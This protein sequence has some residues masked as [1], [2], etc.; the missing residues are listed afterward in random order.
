MCGIAGIVTRNGTLPDEGALRRMSSAIAHRGPDGEGLWLVPG[1]GFAHRRLAIID[2]AQTGAQ[3]MHDVRGELT[4]TYNGEIYNYREL[5]TELERSGAHFASSSDTEVILEGYRV[6]GDDVLPR[7]R[8]MFAFALWDAPKKRMLVARDKTGKKPFFYGFTPSRD[9]VF[10][11]ELKALAAVLDMKP[12]QDAIRLFLGLQYV[13]SPRTGFHE[14]MQ[15]RPG[16]SGVW[17]TDGWRIRRYHEWDPRS[18]KLEA[19]SSGNAGTRAPN[20]KH[21]TTDID[22]EI[23]SKLEDAV[24]IRQLAADVPV[25][26][27]LSGGIDSAAVVAFASRHVSQPLRT[28]T[29]GF[30]VPHMDERTEARLIADTFKTEHHAFVAT[31]SDLLDTSDELIRHYDAPFADSSALPLWLLAQKTANEIKV[32]LTGDGGDELFGGYRRYV[33]YQR[34]RMLSRSFFTTIGVEA[35]GSIISDP[36]WLRMADTMKMLRAD[37]GR[38]YGELFCGSYFSTA[39]L[40]ETFDPGFLAHTDAEDGVAYVA[41]QMHG[42]ASLDAAMRFDLTSYLADDLNVKMD[43]ATMRWGLE[44]RAPFLDQEVIALALSLPLNQKVERGMTKVALRRALRDILPSP[45]LSATKRGFQVPLA[46]WFRGPLAGELKD[47]VLDPSGPLAGYVRHEAV[48]RLITENAHGADHG[49]RLWMLFALSTWLTS[50][51]S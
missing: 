44:A 25:G 8:G 47:R 48:E 38:A 6:W 33:A 2:L 10:A 16:E 30:D 21:Q 37:P 27:F 20:A 28:F 5:R 39:R 11:S 51:V 22:E 13:P 26:A 32:V 1:V 45:I 12:D 24:K 31:P 40:H 36:K 50:H 18:A 3:P 15:L 29:M 14:I 34:A 7:L 17:D 4:I 23:R 19:Q 42:D 43:R 46:E 9:L 35:F 49:N 41:A